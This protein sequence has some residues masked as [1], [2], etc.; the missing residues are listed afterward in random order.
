M[1]DFHFFLLHLFLS[2]FVC[3]SSVGCFNHF[4]LCNL[5]DSLYFLQLMSYVNELLV[6]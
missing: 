4:L 6:M 1:E 5:V 2:S 3:V